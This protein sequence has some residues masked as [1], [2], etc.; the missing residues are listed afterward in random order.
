VGHAEATVLRSDFNLTIPN[1]PFVASVGDD[2]TLKLDFIAA[3][4]TTSI[5][6]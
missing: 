3:A 6:A 4:V 1:V 2:V 5:E